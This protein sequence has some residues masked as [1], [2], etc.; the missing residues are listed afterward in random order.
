MDSGKQ[1]EFRENSNSYVSKMLLRLSGKFGKIRRMTKPVRRRINKT[2]I[3]FLTVAVAVI[4]Y[5]AT[6]TPSPA[7]TPT[8]QSS[9]T[10]GGINSSRARP[11][12]LYCYRK[13]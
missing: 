12:R 10:G 3:A 8:E 7:T 11:L 13:Q 9:D 4:S 5:S 6:H 1:N 2:E